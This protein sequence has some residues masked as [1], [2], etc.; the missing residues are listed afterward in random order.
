MIAEKGFCLC[1]S[2]LINCFISK[3]SN[4]VEEWSLHC[5]L[6]LFSLQC[7]ML[8]NRALGMWCIEKGSLF[9]D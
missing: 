2:G 7:I 9:S 6:N 1:R 3:E 5:S 8:K 4:G